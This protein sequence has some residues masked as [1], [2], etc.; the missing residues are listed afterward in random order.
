MKQE[1]YIQSRHTSNIEYP[2]GSNHHRYCVP[3]EDPE[4]LGHF[5]V[6]QANICVDNC[7]QT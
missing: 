7:A 5:Q 3:K 4:G 1:P 2:V 6:S